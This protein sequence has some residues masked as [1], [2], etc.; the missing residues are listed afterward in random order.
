MNDVAVGKQEE[1]EQ[2]HQNGQHQ[3]AACAHQ[4]VFRLGTQAIQQGI[5][6][7][8]HKIAGAKIGS[9]AQRL[10]QAHIHLLGTDAQDGNVIAK[11]G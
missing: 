11:H 7:L 3:Q 5:Q 6:A 8:T 1:G 4:H 10:G 9:A 2:R